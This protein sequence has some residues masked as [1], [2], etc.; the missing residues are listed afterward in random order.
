MMDAWK[1]FGCDFWCKRKILKIYPRIKNE[2]CSAIEHP[3]DLPPIDETPEDFKWKFQFKIWFKDEG[4]FL[5]NPKFRTFQQ[6]S[7]LYLTPGE[8]PSKTTI[9]DEPFDPQLHQPE[10]E[11]WNHA[12]KYI[13]I[14][15]LIK[16]IFIIIVCF[17][18]L[19]WSKQNISWNI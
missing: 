1:C 13:P 9:Y 10:L 15:S 5:K 3:Y 12:W 19:F 4:N 8:E 14:H 2:M 17:H 11:S 7:D 6:E 16:I 18:F